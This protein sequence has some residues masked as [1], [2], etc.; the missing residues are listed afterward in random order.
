MDGR[1]YLQCYCQ[2][3]SKRVNFQELPKTY[4]EK[5]LFNENI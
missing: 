2:T 3:L 1:K 4:N 5:Y